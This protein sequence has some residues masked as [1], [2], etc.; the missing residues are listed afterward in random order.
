[1]KKQRCS[2]T[3]EEDPDKICVRMGAVSLAPRWGTEKGYSVSL[4]CI[5]D[6]ESK[7][8]GRARTTRRRSVCILGDSFLF[9]PFPVEGGGK[10]KR[11]WSNRASCC[12]CVLS[13]VSCLLLLC[14]DYLHNR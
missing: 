6:K 13:V 11:G 12:F 1:M 7:N 2:H 4:G 9:P 3:D 8:K 10:K 5:E 14:G